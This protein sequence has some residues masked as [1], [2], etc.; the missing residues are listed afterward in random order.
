MTGDRGRPPDVIVVGAGSAGCVLAARLSEDPDRRVLVVE[1]GPDLRQRD[2][3]AALAGPSFLDAVAEPGWVWPDL[4]ARRVDGQPERPYLRGRGIGGSSAVNA[5]VGLWGVPDDYD[6]WERV[7]GCTG[8][9]WAELGPVLAGLPVPLRRARRHEWG[10]V[11]RALEAAGGELGWPTCDDHHRPGAWGVGP[12]WLTQTPDGRR[13]SAADVYVEPARS[14]PNLEIRGDA[15]VDRV[16]LDARCARGVRLADGTELEGNEVVVAAGAI[17]SP[18][19]LAR[20]GVDRPGLGQG[21]QDHPSAGVALQLREPNDPHGLALA[22]LARWSSGRAEADLQLLPMSHLGPTAPGLGLVSLA[23]MQVR[24]RGRVT[25]R[26]ADPHQDPIVELDLLSDE[27]DVETM[28]AGVA[29]L[30][31]L[32]RT[33]P[34]RRLVEAAFLDELGTPFED[35]GDDA[36]EV[37]AWLRRRTG[38]YVHASGTCR[39]GPADDEAAVVDGR[40]RVIGYEGLRVCDASVLPELPRA[41]TH[42]TVVAVAELMARRWALR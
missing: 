23:L 17:H 25:L 35:L 30:R 32:L 33:G 3:P 12:A 21:L 36:G 13:A 8:W 11:D 22:T 26:A 20:S 37:A 24:S 15:L 5:M 27:R 19:V 31:R 42:L 6:R 28:V 14:R 38:D 7:Y 34:F 10:P 2:R 29:V 39:M 9:G 40:G 18:A 16:L 41:N 4:V 1:A